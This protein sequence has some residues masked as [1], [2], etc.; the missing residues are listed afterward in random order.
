MYLKCNLY[1]LN[2]YI[3]IPTKL[4]VHLT[5]MRWTCCHEDRVMNIVTCNPLQMSTQRIQNKLFEKLTSGNRWQR[6]RFCDCVLDFFIII[7]NE[8]GISSQAFIMKPADTR[9]SNV[10][11]GNSCKISR[12]PHSVAGMWRE[13]T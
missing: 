9:I 6:V 2:Y 5:G 10:N 12:A 13:K 7:S 1:N 4:T 11:T 8:P 3:Y